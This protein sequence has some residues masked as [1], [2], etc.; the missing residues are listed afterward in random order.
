MATRDRF[1]ANTF[2]FLRLHKAQGATLADLPLTED[3]PFIEEPPAAPSDLQITA[4]DENEVSLSWV[5]NSGGEESSFEIFMND[6]S[7]DSVASGVTV[8]DDWRPCT[9]PLNVQANATSPNDIEITWDSNDD[10]TLIVEIQSKLSSEPDVNFVPI[11]FET[12]SVG[13]FTA[14]ALTGST[15]YDFRLRSTS[16]DSEWTETVTE[17]TL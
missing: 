1:P 4:F 7:L 15:S 16:P 5:S 14:S 3:T 13:T 11:G 8:Y 2:G 12:S 9:I 17:T 10:G 6:A